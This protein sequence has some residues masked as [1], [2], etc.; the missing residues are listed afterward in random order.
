LVLTGGYR[1]RP[2]DLDAIQKEKLFALLVDLDT[3]EAASQV[4]DLLVK[5]HPADRDKIEL[6]RRL[7]TEHLD[8][9]R[10][11]ERFSEPHHA[12]GAVSQ[13]ATQPMLSLVSSGLRRLGRRVA[14]SRS[15]A[16]RET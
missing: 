1:P 10:V 16:R 6:T 5:T 8:I 12:V 14:G 4:H 15:G 3:Y 9:D 7:V 2:R 13:P 11:L